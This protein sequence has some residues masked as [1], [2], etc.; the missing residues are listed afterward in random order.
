MP[1]FIVTSSRKFM[2]NGPTRLMLIF[3][4]IYTLYY[5]GKPQG[6]LVNTYRKMVSNGKL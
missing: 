2:E 5:I 6:V 1:Y 4:Y 3:L